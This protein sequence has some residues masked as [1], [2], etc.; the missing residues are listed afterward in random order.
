MRPMEDGRIVFLYARDLWARRLGRGPLLVWNSTVQPKLVVGEFVH[1]DPDPD[2]DLDQ[3][4][5]ALS[6]AAF[7]FGPWAMGVSK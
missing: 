6:N 3:S 4:Y 5:P 2:H 1:F 7:I